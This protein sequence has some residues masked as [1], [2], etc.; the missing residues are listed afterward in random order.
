[1]KYLR[2]ILRKDE[3]INENLQLITWYLKEVISSSKNVYCERLLYLLCLLCLLWSTIKTLVSVK[4]VP[5]I[6]PIPVNNKLTTNFKG[7]ANI[8]MIYSV[9]YVNL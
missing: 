7:K 8:S 6:A 3:L 2:S 9:N 4:K 5:V 1:M